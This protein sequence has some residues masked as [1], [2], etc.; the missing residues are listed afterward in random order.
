[1]AR[2]DL[3]LVKGMDGRT[4]SLNGIQPD[5]NG[6]LVVSAADVGA[7]PGGYGLGEKVSTVSRKME[8]IDN[9]T[10]TGW[11]WLSGSA[12]IDGKTI[13]NSLLEQI[14]VS[15]NFAVHMLHVFEKT[16]DSAR[17][18]V[19]LLRSRQMGTWTPWEWDNPPMLHGIE[20]R[21]TERSN[22]KPVY[23]QRVNVGQLPATGST[24]AYLTTKETANIRVVR[25]NIIV[26]SESET[27]GVYTNLPLISSTGTVLAYGTVSSRIDEGDRAA[28]N[29]YVTADCTAYTCTA[30]V[31]YTK[32]TD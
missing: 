19:K 32:S 20:Y 4:L 22:G 8:D 2:I 16:S 24:H 27:R 23:V 10:G 31:W 29:V 28:V 15:D 21:T 5:A 30:D 18:C 14:E 11:F 25:E 6:N 17:G 7:A 26:V 12:S 1:M 3:G 13:G 9:I